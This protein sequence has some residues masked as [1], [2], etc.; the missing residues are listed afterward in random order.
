AVMGES[1]DVGVEVEVNNAFVSGG[2]E[3]VE[4]LG[5]MVGSPPENMTTSG[6]PSERTKASS[7]ASTWSR[8]SEKP[9]GWWPESAK[10]IGQSRLQP[11]FTSSTARQACCLCSGQRP[12]S[13]GQPSTASVWNSSGSVPGLL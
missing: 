13:S 3:E 4:D 11:L 9:S 5:W 2:V 7:P 6:S 8:V 1:E 10:Q 12:Q